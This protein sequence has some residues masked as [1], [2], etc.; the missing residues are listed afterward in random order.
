MMFLINDLRERPEYVESVADRIWRAFW[1]ESGYP[2]EYIASRVAESLDPQPIPFAL[3]AH[4]DGVF[5]GTA[6]VIVSD[7]PARPEYTPWVAAVFVEPEAREQGIGAALVA[8]ASEAAFALGV[9][10][11]FLSTGPMRRPFY[12]KRGWTLCE[13]DVPR[14][15]MA[16]LTRVPT[17]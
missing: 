12:E 17:S 4:A 2:L 7:V 3:V 15:G 11:L 9:K 1:K 5:L 8:H 6:A 16:I 14:P 10:R 13:E